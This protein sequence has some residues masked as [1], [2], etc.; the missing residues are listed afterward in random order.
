MPTC[1]PA[2]VINDT[3]IRFTN[4]DKLVNLTDFWKASGADPSK[5]PAQWLKADTAKA[6]VAE[7]GK[8]E[9]IHLIQ[10][11]R[12]RFGGTFAHW[13]IALAYAK[14]LSP[15]FHIH[16]NNIIRRFVE[17]E[18]NPD[19]AVDRAISAYRR[20]GNGVHTQHIQ[21]KQ[22]TNTLKLQTNI[23]QNLQQHTHLSAHTQDKAPL[24]RAQ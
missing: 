18:Q 6:F 8:G 3:A 21:N 12:G 5:K 15:E 13:Q 22:S 2:L 23:Y 17:E 20:Q 16:C 19:M 7:L 24:P 14:Y 9:D 4:D 1:T 11:T 10:I